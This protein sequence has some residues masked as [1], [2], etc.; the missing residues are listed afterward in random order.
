MANLE[1]TQIFINNSW[2]G[3]WMMKRDE[4]KKSDLDIVSCK[5]CDGNIDLKAS[6]YLNFK[7]YVGGK[8]VDESFFHE[9]C[10]EGEYKKSVAKSAESLISQQVKR[11]LAVLQNLTASPA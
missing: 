10:W 3:K 7:K 4:K 5:F 6:N 11:Q 8:L 9:T 2:W 1:I